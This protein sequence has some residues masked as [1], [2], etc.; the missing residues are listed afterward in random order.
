MGMPRLDVIKCKF[1][2]N[3][4]RIIPRKIVY[5]CAINLMAYATTGKY[6]GT[7]VPELSGMDAVKRFG[8]D[9]NI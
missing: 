1:Y 8:D 5:Y 2:T 6:S 3:I 4:S 9:H 7:V